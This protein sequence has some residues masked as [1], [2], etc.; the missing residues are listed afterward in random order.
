MTAIMNG[1]WALGDRAGTMM[2]TTSRKCWSSLVIVRWYLEIDLEE[3]SVGF[4][5][6]TK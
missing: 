4:T 5:P 3:R 6:E 1:Q 2:L